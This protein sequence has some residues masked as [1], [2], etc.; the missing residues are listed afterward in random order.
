MFFVIYKIRQAL[1][2]FSLMDRNYVKVLINLCIYF[3]QL[4]SIL[5]PNHIFHKKTMF[6]NLMKN[7]SATL[8]I[9]EV[10]VI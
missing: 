7:K 9:Q 1:A 10:S 8:M 4:F 2:I 3:F 6:K 5:T